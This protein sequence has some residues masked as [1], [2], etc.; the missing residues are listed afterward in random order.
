[1]C[2]TTFVRCL[3]RPAR[4]DAYFATQGRTGD[5][6]L[7]AA[8]NAMALSSSPPWR[9]VLRDAFGSRVREC[10]TPGYR[11]RLYTRAGRASVVR[12]STTVP[13]G[14]DGRAHYA[15]GGLRAALLE[16]AAAELLGGYDALDG[17]HVGDA[18]RMLAGPHR[19]RE[20]DFRDRSGLWVDV[21]A[22]APPRETVRYRAMPDYVS[23]A[24][25]RGALV[26]AARVASE[27]EGVLHG[28]A[29]LHAHAILARR[30]GCVLVHDPAGPRGMRLA[31]ESTDAEAAARGM[32]W[33]ADEELR[34]HFDRIQVFERKL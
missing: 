19:V 1:M 24:L 27:R 7:L 25:A 29:P 30:A 14:D 18:V 17:G 10:L 32:V 28:L 26:F 20:R 15:R 9:R 11:V 21:S 3:R 4:H 33:I 22:P 12:V 13:R 31:G 8:V 16:K 34:R 2:M 23:A 6:W 5:C